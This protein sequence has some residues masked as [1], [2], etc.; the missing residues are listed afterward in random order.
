MTSGCVELSAFFEGRA[1]DGGHTPQLLTRD[2]LVAF[3]ADQRHRASH[4][5]PMLVL[6][7]GAPR[8]P[9]GPRQVTPGT[10][11]EVFTGARQIPRTAL[12]TGEYERLGLDRGFIIA[13]PYGRAPRGRRRKPFSDEVA[14]ALAAEDNL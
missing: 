1:P 5:L 6:Q 3:I 8:G 13:L 10:A 11:A 4:G 9:Q 7:R 12:E 2:H 14:R